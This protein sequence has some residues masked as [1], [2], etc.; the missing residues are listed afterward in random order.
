M[1]T[2]DMYTYFPTIFVHIFLLTYRLFRSLV[3][4]IFAMFP[5]G[6]IFFLHPP[7]AFLKRSPLGS[8]MAT[9]ISG[10]ARKGDKPWM[11]FHCLSL[12]A[13]NWLWFHLPLL[14]PWDLTPSETPG[15]S[16]FTHIYSPS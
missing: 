2:W 13:W 8:A 5:N 12:P 1:Y 11:N 6:L 3:A 7:S 14:T 4:Y 16:I 10:P 15:K 9:S